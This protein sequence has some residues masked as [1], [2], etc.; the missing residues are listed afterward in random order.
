MILPILLGLLLLLCSCSIETIVSDPKE[1]D[2]G[3]LREDTASEMKAG[4]SDVS[5]VQQTVDTSLTSADHKSDSAAAAEEAARKASI[6]ESRAQASR[7]AAEEAARNASIEES[8]AQASRAAAEES[9]RQEEIRRA[10]E[11]A[12]QQDDQDGG[13]VSYIANTNTGKF[14]YPYCASVKRMNEE[15]KWYFHGSRSELIDLGY[16]PCKNCNP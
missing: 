10:A 16:E 6:E 2:A 8:R 11:E 9:A 14:H 13:A 3:I 1:T 15:N 12:K 5:E 4:E 7:A